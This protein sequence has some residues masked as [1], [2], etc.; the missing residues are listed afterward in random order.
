M[1]GWSF[2]HE[3]KTITVTDMGRRRVDLP[4][5]RMGAVP[6][7]EYVDY[8]CDF[9]G[10]RDD[11]EERLLTLSESLLLSLID[12][13]RAIQGQLANAFNAP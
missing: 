7:S 2:D 12:P 6:G 10:T 13:E 8:A 9:K 1:K 3:G 5:P 4:Y 11:G